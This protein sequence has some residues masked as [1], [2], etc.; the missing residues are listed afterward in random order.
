MLQKAEG[1]PINP[2][3]SSVV[4]ERSHNF[5]VQKYKKAKLKIEKVFLNWRIIIFFIGFL[6]GRATILSDLT[7]FALPFFASVYVLRKERSGIAGIALLAGAV[8]TVYTNG[9]FVLSCLILFILIQSIAKKLPF[10]E[11]KLL[12][13]VVFG[14]I[15]IT[16]V[17]INYL[18]TSQITVGHWAISIVEAGLSCILTLIFLQSIP[19]ISKKKIKRTLKN[20]EIICFIILLASVMTGTIG[21]QVYGMSVE[22]ILSRFLVILFAF[23]GGAAIGSTV[24]VVTGIILGLA[25]VTNLYQMSLLAFSGLLGGLL[26]EG[27]KIGVSIG[28]LIGTLLLSLYNGEATLSKPILE[29]A[30]A[31]GLFL[32]TPKQAITRIARIIPGTAEYSQEQ[33]Q[34]VQ[35]VRDVTATR[36]QQFSSL[37]QVL[38]NS[39]S[40][41]HLHPQKELESNELDLFLSNVTE[42]TCQTCFKKEQ[43]WVNNFDKTYDY[44]GKIM[45]EIDR[46][47]EIK[48]RSLQFEWNKHCVKSQKTI[49]TIQYELNR[50]KANMK[51]KHQVQESRK[52]VA[53][54]LL[55]VSQVMGNFAKEIQKE[56][57]NHQQQE[58]QIKEAIENIGLEIGHIDI[59]SL[60]EG[61]IDIDMSIPYCDGRGECE[62]LIAPILSDILEETVL[63]R[64]EDCAFYPNGYCHVNFGSAKEYVVET[65]IASAA[66]GG[67]WISGDSHS[68]MELG[69]GKFAVAI[70]DGMGN[71]ERAHIES[72][73]TL[74]LLQ[75][76]LQSGIDETVAIK[77]VNSVLA[78]RTTDEIFSTLDLAM[79]DLQ[80]ASVKFLKIGSTPSFIKRGT[81]VQMVEVGNL[82]MGIVEEFDVDV[83]SAQLKAGDLLIMM[84]DGIYDGPKN[85]ENK[86]AWL[87]RKI[88]EIRTE[89]PQEIADLLLE[90][91]IR[92]D[93]GH[94]EDDMT[95]VVL[96]IE[97]NIPKWA[98]IPI[99]RKLKLKKQA[100]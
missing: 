25:N 55:G 99:P 26:K 3:R 59:Y 11:Y 49:E 38:S 66:K 33:Q 40:N 64:K 15:L 43:C 93:Y 71:G 74:K 75:T 30:I 46:N 78:L 69:S 44:M 7:P 85:V 2:L 86:D 14:S 98:S 50:Y 27:K 81:D 79:V 32:L 34:Y 56:R 53:D 19:L 58:D 9:L 89:E 57:V 1:N 29:S 51:L 70:S 23:V 45:N 87:K 22:H 68:T 100:N 16:R 61:N 94:I 31:I 90:E 67:A 24:G 73:E 39:F 52:L 48:N 35:K 83:V 95:V 8:S 12:P 54:Q 91:V 41:A 72:N 10:R 37:F 4:V 80:D 28:L 65:G 96:K 36:V 20:E 18:L 62:K 63:V 88:R 82:P 17:G 77:S 76:I 42:K 92:S 97:K 60:E 13:I 6:L 21:W 5:A 84:S 47:G